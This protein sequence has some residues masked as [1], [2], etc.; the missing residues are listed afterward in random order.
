M[1]SV[2]LFFQYIQRLKADV[3]SIDDAVNFYLP[4][5]NVKNWKF[6]INLKELY[7]EFKASTLHWR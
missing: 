1:Y 4:A 3:T 2:L 6:V 5:V 7:I